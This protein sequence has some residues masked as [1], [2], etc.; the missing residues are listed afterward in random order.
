MKII[1]LLLTFAIS[2]FTHANGQFPKVI[3][4][5]MVDADNSGCLAVGYNDY[6]DNVY[7]DLDPYMTPKYVFKNVSV[8]AYGKV[9]TPSY[10]IY[11]SGNTDIL[12]IIYFE[13]NYINYYP[14]GGTKTTGMLKYKMS[15]TKQVEVNRIIKAQ[16]IGF[17]KKELLFSRSLAKK[18][19]RNLNKEDQC[20]Q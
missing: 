3:K 19:N 10:K 4:D 6:F 9:F 11:S 1:L 13:Q 5:F 20:N 16:I 15:I 14:F 12:E 8:E 7:F 18:W 17:E 2:N